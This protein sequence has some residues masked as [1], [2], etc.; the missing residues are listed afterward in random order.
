MIKCIDPN[1]G[2]ALRRGSTFKPGGGGPVLPPM[3]GRGN[4]RPWYVQPCLCDWA[5]K[6]SCVTY[7]ER[8][9]IV[10]CG[11]F[12]PS[13]IHQVIITGINKLWL[14]LLALKMTSDANW[15]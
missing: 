14:Y 3:K 8:N 6:R 12:P 11:Q 4:Q 13:F 9:E 10:S 15:V 7:G 1:E 5:Y 2:E